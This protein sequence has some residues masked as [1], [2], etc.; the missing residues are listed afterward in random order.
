M[1][2]QVRLYS[3]IEYH[4]GHLDLLRLKLML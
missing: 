2:L 4:L 3:G 1:L